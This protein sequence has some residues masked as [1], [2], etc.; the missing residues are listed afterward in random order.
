MP[1]AELH[2]HVEGTLE[3]DM[4]FALAERN[5]IS[6]DPGVAQALRDG[7]PFTDL[8]SFLDRY[9]ACSSVLR[10][11]QDFFDLA[12]AYL[13]RAAAY[14]MAR[15]GLTSSFTGPEE[16]RRLVERLDAFTESFR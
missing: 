1:K 9:Y 10:T 4:A 16:K 5:G 3:P 8:Q 7:R 6:L 14:R 11:E 15:S 12:R 13:A 2:V